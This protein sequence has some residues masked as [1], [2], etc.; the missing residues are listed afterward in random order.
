MPVT[1]N[2]EWSLHFQLFSTGEWVAALRGVVKELYE[3]HGLNPQTYVHCQAEGEMDTE[4]PEDHPPMDP[5]TQLG[6][7]SNV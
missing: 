1:N 2:I 4:L 7:C 5:S 3:Y 6:M